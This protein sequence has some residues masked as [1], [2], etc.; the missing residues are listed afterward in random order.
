MVALKV[1]SEAVFPRELLAC[2]LAATNRTHPI[3]RTLVLV[4][5]LLVPPQVRRS[6]PALGWRAS[7]ADVLFGVMLHMFA[8][9]CE[10]IEPSM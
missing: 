10:Q 8:A 5:F 9:G 2:F 4:D 1:P 3:C 6:S 7:I